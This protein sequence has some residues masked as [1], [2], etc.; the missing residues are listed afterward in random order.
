MLALRLFVGLYSAQNLRD[1]GGISRQLVWKPFERRKV[2]EQGC[3]TIWAFKARPQTLRWI[4]ALKAHESR[5]KATAEAD[6]AWNSVG[7]LRNLGL[8]GYVPHLFEN[9]TPQAEIIHPYGIGGGC[10]D[11]IDKQLADAAD[12]AANAMCLPG[13]VENAINHGFVH[14]CPVVNTRPDVQMIGVARL[15]YRPHTQRTSAWYAEL[16]SNAQTFI[17]RYRELESKAYNAAGILEP[18]L[19]SA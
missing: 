14:F 17:G 4:G 5:P 1:N 6:P 12:D 11:A 10:E 9:S 19:Q 16:Q 8:L 18:N 13:P 2:A 15:R 3:Y 7:L